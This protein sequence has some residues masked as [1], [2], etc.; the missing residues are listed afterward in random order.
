MTHYPFADE[1]SQSSNT[2]QEKYRQA[3]LVLEEGSC[4]HGYAFGIA[5][6]KVGELVFNTSMTGYQEILTDPS[7]FQ[8]IVVLTYPHIGNTGANDEDMESAK[9]W[10]SGLVTRDVPIL[11]SNWRSQH[12]LPEW[13]RQQRALGISGIDTRALTNLL[14]HKGA[15]KGCILVA[16]DC[17][18]EVALQAAKNFRGLLNADLAKEVSTK[19]VYQWQ[20]PSWQLQAERSTSKSKGHIAVYDFG[21]KRNML[22]LLVDKGYTLSVF[23]ATTPAVEVLKSNPDGV[24]LSNGPG[25]PQ[26]CDYAIAAIQHLLA[27][28]IPI[29]GICLGHQLL[30]LASGAKTSKMKFGHHGANH[31]VQGPTGTV[32]I[33]SQ[34][35]GFAVDEASLPAHLQVTHRS[36]FDHTIQGIKHL[37]APAIGFQGHPEASPGPHDL[38]GIFATFDTMILQA[39]QTS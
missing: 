12:T 18:Y 10:C 14:R 7:Y 27:K 23:P 38:H 37:D 9:V 31:P 1:S 36:L 4:F 34:N 5:G 11:P 3:I 39:K 15:Q 17:D 25:D 8:Q 16:D 20:Q 2:L 29:L 30:A 13:M 19:T 24:L 21:V 6:M 22:R 32:A 35:H 28:K 26:P 33:S